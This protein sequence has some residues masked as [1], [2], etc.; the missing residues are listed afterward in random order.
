M[1]AA[2]SAATVGAVGYTIDDLKP[3]P[4]LGQFRFINEN[5]SIEATP[6]N[7]SE[8]YGDRPDDIMFEAT[9]PSRDIHRLLKLGL[10]IVA[11]IAVAGALGALLLLASIRVGVVTPPL[12]EYR[13]G[14]LEVISIYDR[15]AC[16]PKQVC[17]G[18]T[19]VLYLGIRT[20]DET[21]LGLQVIRRP[22]Q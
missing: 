9:Q 8:I 4:A 19:Y 12:G 1:R 15:Q 6:I 16:L 21:A 7:L 22:S 13:F 2:R 18:D 17:A 10:T 3:R 20:A 14:S 11:S 5:G